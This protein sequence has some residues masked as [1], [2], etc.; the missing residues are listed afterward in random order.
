MVAQINTSINTVSSMS[1]EIGS[2]SEQLASAT[3]EQSAQ[4]SEVAAATEEMA[5]T[6]I[7]NSRVTTTVAAAAEGSGATAR[8]GVAI[9]GETLDKINRIADVVRSA[10]ATVEALGS[11]SEQVG[12]IVQVID[13]IANQTNLLALN[14]AIEAARAGE[15]GRGFAVVADEVRKLAERTSQATGQIA[16]MIR[17]IQTETG[18]AVQS[19]RIGSRE[20]EEGIELAGRAGDVLGEI[21]TSTETT[22]DMVNQIAA[23]IEEQSATSEQISRSIEMISTSSEESARGIN[24]IA[25][26]VDGLGRLT[27]DLGDLVAR[28][29]LVS[30][31]GHDTSRLTPP[32]TTFVRQ[33]GDRR[34]GSPVLTE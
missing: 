2:A 24:Q 34:V 30:S 21:R 7:D 14:A 8:N 18:D 26:S 25:R 17:S 31:G 33:T 3:Q 12:E 32:T 10:A 6:I 5:R 16:S 28:F 29:R 1:S 27:I 19:M 13:D 4:T 9:V 22:V 20:V 15:Q 11:S 23:A